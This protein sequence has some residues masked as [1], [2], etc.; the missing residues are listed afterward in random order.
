[1]CVCVEI[2]VSLRIGGGQLPKNWHTF[3]L[4]LSQNFSPDSKSPAL[5][6]YLF[7]IKGYRF[8]AF[9]LSFNFFSVRK[10]HNIDVTSKEVPCLPFQ[11]PCEKKWAARCTSVFFSIVMEAGT[12]PQ[13]PCEEAH[14]ER[15]CLAIVTQ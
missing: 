1:M 5:S 3:F 9:V 11:Q 6:F 7:S 4:P 14:T 15:T 13:P 12:S 8:K 2:G 10:V